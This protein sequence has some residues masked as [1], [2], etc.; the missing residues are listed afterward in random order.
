MCFSFDIAA[1]LFEVTIAAANSKR[2][3]K[4]KREKREFNQSE[5]QINV[6]VSTI[7]LSHKSMYSNTAL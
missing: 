5:K 1:V 6:T 3:Y 7:F 2:I 4:K